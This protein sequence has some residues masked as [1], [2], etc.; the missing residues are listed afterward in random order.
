MQVIFR[1]WLLPEIAVQVQDA[2][3]LARGPQQYAKNGR[4][5]AVGNALGQLQ[6]RIFL[7]TAAQDRFAALETSLCQL[8]AEMKSTRR[9][10]GQCP[11]LQHAVVAIR[12]DNRAA[13]GIEN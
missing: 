6:F 12:E 4:H 10:A 2:D 7:N 13:L 3:S 1:K 8:L 11:Q 9:V 5:G